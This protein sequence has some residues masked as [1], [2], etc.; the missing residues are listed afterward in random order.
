M[1]TL[2]VCREY[3]IIRILTEWK[4]LA[5]DASGTHVHME[6]SINTISVVSGFSISL[7]A[8]GLDRHCGWD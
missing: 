5:S 2:G 6:N 4:E 8:N 7:P 3:V 1:S